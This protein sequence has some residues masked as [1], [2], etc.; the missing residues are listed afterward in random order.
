MI[1]DDLV[2]IFVLRTRNHA[3]DMMCT[4]TMAIEAGFEAEVETFQK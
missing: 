3:I 2:I 4:N 1:I